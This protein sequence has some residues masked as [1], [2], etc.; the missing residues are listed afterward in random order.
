MHMCYVGCLNLYVD[1]QSLQMGCA[2]T[3]WDVVASVWNVAASIGAIAGAVW[4]FIVPICASQGIK[5]LRS[6]IP[7]QCRLFKWKK[8]EK[9]N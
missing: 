8:E 5:R 7:P 3:M 2:G 9:Q 1:C 6:Q 4:T